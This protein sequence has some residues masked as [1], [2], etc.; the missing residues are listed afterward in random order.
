M[1]AI[2]RGIV[3]AAKKVAQSEGW[4]IVISEAV[5]GNIKS[6]SSPLERAQTA[7]SNVGKHVTI[8]LEAASQTPIVSSMH[9]SVLARRRL[10]ERQKRSKS[11]RRTIVL[12]GAFLRYIKTR[13]S[14]PGRGLN[15]LS[16]TL[17]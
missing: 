3:V 1:L 17:N 10:W 16:N 2:L 7:L 4:I 12:C 9:F 11:G 6:R 5:P 14:A 8:A 15:Y 13:P